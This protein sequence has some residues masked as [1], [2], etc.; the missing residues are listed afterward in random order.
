[1]SPDSFP[2]SFVGKAEEAEEAGSRGAL[3]VGQ[4][5]LGDTLPLR[6]WGSSALVGDGMSPDSFPDSL[7]NPF[8][9]SFGEASPDS[10]ADFFSD[11]ISSVFSIKCAGRAERISRLDAI[12]N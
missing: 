1:M 9:D 7:P 6:S 10:F 2:D 5:N 12:R 3:S 8:R 4:K 11:D